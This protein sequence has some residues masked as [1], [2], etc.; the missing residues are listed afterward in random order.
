MMWFLLSLTH[1]ITHFHRFNLNVLADRLMLDFSLSGLALGNLAA[2]YS[3]MYLLVQIP[4]G[5]LIDRFG[6][7]R[8]AFATA[9]LMGTGSLI[10]GFSTSINGIFLGRLMIGLGGSVVL[11]NIIKFQA[12]WYRDN[13]FAT[14][15]GLAILIGS[16][17]SLLAT[18]PLAYIIAFVSW[19]VIFQAAGLLSFL[20]ALACLLLVKD[21]PAAGEGER[22]LP[23][24]GKAEQSYSLGEMVSR[25]LRNRPLWTAFFLNF[26]IY[27]SFV[28]LTGAWGV[29]YVMQIYG[30]TRPEAAL[31]MLPASLGMM[32][33]APLGGYLSDRLGRRKLPILIAVLF[34]FLNWSLLLT[35]FGGKPPLFLLYIITFNLG[36]A[37]AAVTLTLTY[38]KEMSPPSITAT[39]TAFVNV[40]SFAGVAVLQILFGYVL[41]RGW[42]GS[43]REGVMLY[44]SGAY[45]SAFFLC[46]FFITISLILATRLRKERS[47]KS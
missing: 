2:A 32:L 1:V 44:P 12:A 41:Q 42:E 35:F 8:M 38:A 39:A 36:A 45:S 37:A 28:T 40:G 13:Q 4:G 21:R 47:L 22:P 14:M 19:R 29:T 3:Y 9:L 33:G 34:F 15:S 7:R 16:A 5:L 23:Q 30:L 43:F 27:G 31:I 26:G 6:P 10:F 46:F 25:T 18:L 24:T 11:I 17:G 20:V